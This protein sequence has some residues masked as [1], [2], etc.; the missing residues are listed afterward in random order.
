MSC[1]EASLLFLSSAKNNFDTYANYTVYLCAETIGVLFGSGSKTPHPCTSCQ[2]VT[3]EEGSS[4]VHRWQEVFS[5]AELWHENRPNQ[6]KPVF[7]VAAATPGHTRG[8]RPFPTVLYGNGD[9]S[10]YQSCIC[11]IFTNATQS[12]VINCITSVLYCCFNESPRL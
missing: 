2:S 9:A 4:Y 6:M 8:N 7:T 12:L 5:H 11:S 3:D 10:K 1:V